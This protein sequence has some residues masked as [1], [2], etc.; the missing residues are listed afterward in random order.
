MLLLLLFFSCCCCCCCW[1]GCRCSFF[2][3]ALPG[4]VDCRSTFGTVPEPVLLFS[5]PC[6]QAE[7]DYYHLLELLKDYVALVGAV[8]DAL[9]ER[10]RAFQSWEH[11]RHTLLRKREQRSR[12][13]MGGRAE[14]VPAAS[15][16]V[17][18]FSLFAKQ[19]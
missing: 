16:E 11:A 14:R 1:S 4:S 3:G 2:V 10:A 17:R 9:G 5:S 12:L 15:D 6:R 8:K 18:L 7:A 19:N 13:E